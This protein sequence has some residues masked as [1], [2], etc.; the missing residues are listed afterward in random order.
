MRDMNLKLLAKSAAAATHM[1]KALANQNRLLVLCQLAEKEM[2]VTELAERVGLS[3][4]AL[5]Q[6]L[7]GLRTAGVVRPRR[8][9]RVVYYGLNDGPAARL[10]AVLADI[11]CPPSRPAAKRGRAVIGSPSSGRR[12]SRRAGPDA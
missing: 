8:Q 12:S 9:S 1:L 3:L 2:T 7:A 4:S 11:Y 10:M 6:H 5:S